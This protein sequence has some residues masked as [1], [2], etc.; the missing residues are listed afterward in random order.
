MI[1]PCWFYLILS[2]WWFQ[3]FFF[4]IFQISYMG[5]HPK[6][7]DEVHDFS[8]IYWKN[9]GDIPG[10]FFRAQS[11]VLVVVQNLFGSS[12]YSFYIS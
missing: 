3:T 12:N 5:C 9:T 1:S 11:K 6:P 7:I 2:G 10:G 8:G 4:L